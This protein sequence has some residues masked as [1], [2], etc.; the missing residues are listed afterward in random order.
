MVTVTTLYPGASPDEIE[1]LVSIP[2][3]KEIRSVTGIKEVR[4]FN[5]ENVSVI[6]VYLEPGLPDTQKAVDDITDAVNRVQD[7]P[8]SVEKPLVEEITTEKQTVIEISL[9]VKN[10]SEEGA[11]NTNQPLNN[12]QYRSLRNL[13]KQL[14]DE[15][16][17]I[18]GIAEVERFGYL[19]REFLVEVRPAAL[20]A[21]QIGLNTFLNRIRV[22]GLDL[23][24][25][26]MRIGAEEYLLRTKGQFQTA[27]QIGTIPLIAN[28]VGFNTRI[29]DVATVTDTFEEPNKLER[30]D[31]KPAIILRIWKN[32]AADLLVMSD[33]TR[34]IIKSYQDRYGDEFEINYF[35]DASV[36]VRDQLFS[37]ITNAGVGLTLLIIV[38]LLLLGPRLSLIVGGVIPVVFMIAFIAMSRAGITLNI[39]SIFALVMVLGMIVDFAIVVSENSYRHL[40]NG[41]EK[42]KAV[43]QG[44]A[45]VF[46]PVTVTVLCTVSAFAPLLFMTGILGKFVFSIPMVIIICLIAAW[47]QAMFI[48]P[49]QLDAFMKEPESNAPAADAEPKQDR[50]AMIQDLYKATLTKALDRRYLTFGALS[51]FFFVSL[52]IGVLS[53]GFVLFPSGGE[54]FIEART[55]MPQGTNLKTNA[56]AIRKLEQIATE[57]AGRY[58]VNLRTRIGIEEPTGD[59]APTEGT[60]RASVIIELIPS[61][62]R[63]TDATQIMNVF[64]KNVKTAIEQGVL[65][66]E[67]QA[68][69]QLRRNGPPVGMPVSIEIRGYEFDVMNEIA[70]IYIEELKN[71][72]GVYGIRTDLE[73][74]KKEF[75]FKVNERKAAQAGVS[76]LTVA[77]AIRTA[78]NG[79]VAT[80]VNEGEDEIEVTVR[81]PEELR[82]DVNSLNQV[83]VANDKRLLIPLKNVASYEIKPGFSAINRKDYRRIGTVQANIDTEVTTSLK[84]NQAL[85]EKFADLESKYPGYEIS[86]GG[87]QEDAQ[88]SVTDLLV[89]F[90]FALLIIFLILAAFY[91]SLSTPAVIMA[92]IPFGMTGVMWGLILHQQPLS[93]MSLLGAVSLSGVIVSNTLVLV[94]FIKDLRESGMNLRESLIEGGATRLR[95]VLLTTATTVLGLLPSVYGLGGTDH[96]VQPLAQGFAYGLIF[97][98]FITLL[99]TPVLYSIAQDIRSKVYGLIGRDIETMD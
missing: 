86:Y 15:V 26:V 55:R 44:T 73:P 45:E 20:K 75:R 37:L 58:L 93:F 89:S 6:V 95:P 7:L 23:P 79:E 31:R 5:I 82:R 16:F 10:P 14:E 17:D 53:T 12:E 29:K 65:P 84:V 8:D 13:A 49:A 46:W 2:I 3:E 52:I 92:A 47:V 78:F 74:G 62:E 54:D 19:D 43:E 40:Q 18:R 56:D 61:G 59:P 9:S 66:R 38:L 72:E 97:A 68:N 83:Y 11:R 71:T 64:R 28:D 57:T 85:A 33:Q 67:L 21:G 48:L 60:H 70:N 30:F 34:E 77:S 63:D 39:V 81:F 27:E 99:L 35:N 42:R 1:Q 94:S 96:F 25:G 90:V 24:S 41:M 4:G 91:K 51:G 87:E 69:I 22:T 76:T 80:T 32:K 50:F 98:T 88:E 36:R